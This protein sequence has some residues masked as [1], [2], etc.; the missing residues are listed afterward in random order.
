[1][2]TEEQQ[3]VAQHQLVEEWKRA[4]EFLVGESVFSKA[5]RT[6]T[7]PAILLG[8]DVI[9]VS[10][11]NSELHTEVIVRALRRSGQDGG[12]SAQTEPPP[13]PQEPAADAEAVG[14]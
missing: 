3:D 8:G 4:V 12:V 9:Y 14:S 13:Q 6:P 5:V 10:S 2:T 1:M 11:S 7:G